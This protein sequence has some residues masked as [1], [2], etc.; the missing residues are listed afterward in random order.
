MRLEGYPTRNELFNEAFGLLQSDS[1]SILAYYLLP[2]VK[3]ETKKGPTKH[4]NE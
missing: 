2:W 3:S 4:Q 1:T